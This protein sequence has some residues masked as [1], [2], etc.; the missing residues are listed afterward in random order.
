MTSQQY[1]EYEAEVA[2]FF[3]REG[4]ANLMYDIDQNRRKQ[5]LVGEQDPTIEPHFSWYFCDVCN[6]QEGGDRYDASGYNP[7]ELEMQSDYSVCPDCLYYAENGQ[8]DDMTMLA[9]AH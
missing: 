3:E 9:I 6:R 4:L 1:A 8:L 2:A 7:T 5:G